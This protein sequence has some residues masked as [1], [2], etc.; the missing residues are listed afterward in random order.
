MG[1]A[2]TGWGSAL[3][4]KVLTNEDL[5]GWLD[6]S[7]EWIVERT[8]IRERRVGGVTSELALESS[9]KAMDRAG[10]KP[11][12]IDALLVATTTPDQQVP[13]V[14]STVQHVLGLTCGAFD[15]NAA[16]SGFVYGLVVAHGL[17]AVGHRCVL[18]VGADALSRI[19]DWDDRSTAVLF[20]D[21][22]GAVVL[23]A[24][25]EEHLL[26]W[27]LGSEGADR[28]LLYCDT[29]GYLQMNG[30]EVFRRAVR[31]MVDSTERT[32][33]RAS[34]TAADIDLLVPHQANQR[35]VDAAIRRLGIPEDKVV[36]TLDRTGN[37]S[38]G[39]IPLALA[40]AADQ[41]RAALGDHV[42]LVGFG[43][44]MTSASALLRWAR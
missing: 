21:G 36:S 22:G 12:D 18:L 41:G 39:S 14:A 10:R 29:G 33:A 9:R 15:L 7:D 25:D 42:L 6:T 38:A 40:E 34:M 24:V 28:G 2:V 37:T 32:L 30:P 20:G 44:G 43:A 1:S 23:E 35:I 31:V 4:E 8:G 17:L 3:P 5:T 27:D 11:E 26:G 13:A 16:C 19:T